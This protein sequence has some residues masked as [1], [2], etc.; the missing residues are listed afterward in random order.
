MFGALKCGYLV[1]KIEVK[2][3]FH[4]KIM[5]SQKGEPPES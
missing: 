5:A 4:N 3:T 1:D 2:I